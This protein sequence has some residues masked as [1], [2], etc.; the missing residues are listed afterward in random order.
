M[1]LRR[2]AVKHYCR[3]KTWGHNMHIMIIVEY[4][5]LVHSL[6]MLFFWYSCMNQNQ[7]RI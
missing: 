2:T 6:P 5:C 1:T 3:S 4:V 7:S